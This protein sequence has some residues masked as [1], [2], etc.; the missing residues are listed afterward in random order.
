MSDFHYQQRK[1]DVASLQA[2]FGPPWTAELLESLL[3]HYEGNMEETV[4]KLLVLENHHNGKNPKPLVDKIVVSGYHKKFGGG[5]STFFSD[6]HGSGMVVSLPPPP[7]ATGT[8]ATIPKSKLKKAPPPRKV[9]VDVTT[10]D[11]MGGNTITIHKNSR[12]RV[13]TPMKL[14]KDFLRIPK[15]PSIP[16]FREDTLDQLAGMGPIVVQQEQPPPPSP[17]TRP[18][19]ASSKF[20]ALRNSMNFPSFPTTTT[21]T[22]QPDAAMS[23]SSGNNNNTMKRFLGGGSDSSKIRRTQSQDSSG[24]GGN[25]SSFMGKFTVPKMTMTA[26]T[27]SMPKMQLPLP[28]PG[29]ASS[30]GKDKILKK[31]SAAVKT[32]PMALF[33]ALPGGNSNNTSGA[34]PLLP[35]TPPREVFHHSNPSPPDDDEEDLFSKPNE[36]DKWGMSVPMT[37]PSKDST[38]TDSAT[39]NPENNNKSRWSLGGSSNNSGKRWSL[40][41]I[42]TTVT[43]KATNMTTTAAEE[44]SSAPQKQPSRWGLSLANNVGESIDQEE[45]QAT[46]NPESKRWSLATMTMTTKKTE[47]EE[48]KASRWVLPLLAKNTGGETDNNSN[49]MVQNQEKPQQQQVGISSWAMPKFT[50]SLRSQTSSNV[51]DAVAGN[52]SDDSSTEEIDTYGAIPQVEF[53]G[54]TLKQLQDIVHKMERQC[55]KNK[56]T[57]VE[58]GR[59]LEPSQVTMYDLVKHFILPKTRDHS[60]SYVEQAHGKHHYDHGMPRPPKWFV[61][62]TWSDSIMDLVHNIQQHAA[63]RSS[64]EDESEDAM[65][66]ICAFAMNQHAIGSHVVAD[67]DKLSDDSLLQDP[68]L[69]RKVLEVTDGMLAVIDRK[70]VFFSRVWCVWELFLALER[71]KSCDGAHVTGKAEGPYLLDVYTLNEEGVSV[72][73]TS[74]VAEADKYRAVR[75]EEGKDNSIAPSAQSRQ[76]PCHRSEWSELRTFRQ[77]RFR[78]QCCKKAL[79]VNLEMTHSSLEEDTRRI[80]NYIVQNKRDDNPNEAEALTVHPAYAHVNALIRGAFAGMAYRRALE[81]SVGSKPEELSSI[82]LKRAQKALKASPMTHL[83]VSFAGCP[84]FQIREALKFVESLPPSLQHLDL[85]Y[86]FLDFQYAEEFV[87]GLRHLSENLETFKLN[88]SFCSKL[89]NLDRLWEELGNLVNLRSL[90]LVVHPHKNVTSVDGLAVALSKLP[91]LETLHLDFDCFGEYS[92][93]VA[94]AKEGGATMKKRPSTYRSMLRKSNPSSGPMELQLQQ[95]DISSKLSDLDLGGAFICDS[96]IRQ[97]CRALASRRGL[98]SLKLGFLGDFG[99]KLKGV[100]S[101][102]DLQKKLQQVRKSLKLF[103]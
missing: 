76:Q 15:K 34:P 13:G 42:S 48:E 56:W 17:T 65:Y 39:T 38:T 81:D 72:G 79:E 61:A 50:G 60:C 8:V 9:K 90:C 64:L 12:R 5:P 89:D 91:H 21:T 67:L 96:S 16:L 6:H 70:D 10:A 69:T 86:S 51:D 92:E 22:K 93:M 26:P 47:A 43:T 62:H 19:P 37:V 53:R 80:M 57:S 98:T 41:A 52:D 78:F 71:M 28:F 11:G 20:Q 58:T 63:D 2:M 75:V 100:E 14:P 97:L 32:P 88:L 18:A 59:P 68:R 66:W 1:E 31:P 36:D 95:F 99:T 25:S 55:V 82:S 33:G 94:M 83:E 7:T 23:S 84:Y 102:E 30:P 24:S 35:K 87:I 44:D 103:T 85:D 45:E 4:N 3:D 46:K 77:A 73:L 74:G 101:A 27:I 49:K 29:A 54:I 40:P